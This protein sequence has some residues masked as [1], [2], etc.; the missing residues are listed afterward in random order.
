MK[1]GVNLFPKPFRPFS[2]NITIEDEFDRR[3]MLDFL[4]MVLE[5]E[6]FSSTEDQVKIN[7]VK[8]VLLNLRDTIRHTSVNDKKKHSQNEAVRPYDPSK[9]Q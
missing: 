1:V 7:A 2:A 9:S 4:E 6:K 3:Q 8:A 5:D